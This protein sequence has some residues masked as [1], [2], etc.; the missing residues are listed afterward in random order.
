MNTHQRN[1]LIDAGLRV[2]DSGMVDEDDIWSHYSND[3]VDIGERL[4][5]VIRTIL[6]SEPLTKKLRALSIGS[7]SEP[8]FRILETAFRGGLYLM[9]IDQSALDRVEE[10]IRRQYTDHVTTVRGNYLDI[11]NHKG[12]IKKL[13]SDKLNNRRIDLIT[14]HHSLYYCT[15]EL[16]L[17]L[18]EA[19]HKNI[20]SSRGALHAVL[21][22]DKSTDITTT[23]WLY[24]HFAGKFFGVRNNQSLPVLKMELEQSSVFRDSQILMTTSSVKFFVDDFEKMMKVIWMILLYPNVHSYT[25]SQKLEIICY[26]I[27]NFWVKRLPLIQKQHHLAVYRG[28][29]FPGIL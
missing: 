15:E 25:E 7:S 21:M 6:I 3:K 20:L 9:D 4:A 11:L 1:S 13:L 16:W 10:R 2:A 26:V 5:K 19:L 12:F 28:V 8:Q 29:D 23:T 18:F 24:N 17:P 14:L 27:D 22:A